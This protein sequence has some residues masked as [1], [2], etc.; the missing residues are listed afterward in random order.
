VDDGHPTLASVHFPKTAG[1][2]FGLALRQCYGSGLQEGYAMLASDIRCARTM[3]RL[4][5][6]SIRWI[7]RKTGRPATR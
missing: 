1:T 7:R 3:C 6:P 5:S 2:S 4:F